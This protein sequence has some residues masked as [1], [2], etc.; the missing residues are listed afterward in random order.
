MG[1]KEFQE[2]PYGL[3]DHEKWVLDQIIMKFWEAK[4]NEE[5]TECELECYKEFKRMGLNDT[6]V[7]YLRDND[8]NRLA[9]ELTHFHEMFDRVPHKH[10]KRMVA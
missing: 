4:S 1:S 2:N 6:W 5:K 3:S 8:C 7:D 9:E 10:E